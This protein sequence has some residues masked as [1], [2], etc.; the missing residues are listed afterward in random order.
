MVRAMTANLTI[1]DQLRSW[2]QHRR[3]SQLDLAL[4]ANISPRHLSFVETGRAQPSRTMILHLCEQLQVPLRERNLLLLAAGFAPIFPERA[5]G[6]PALAAARA[7]IGLVVDGHEPYPA[8]AVDRHWHL[9][10]ANQAATRLLQGIDPA[11][12]APPV[13]A[14][15]ISLHPWGLAP[16]IRNLA[17]WRGH[18][19]ARLR[20]QIDL[21]A[22][23]ALVALH[24]ELKSYPAPA[25]TAP[26]DRAG[27]AA[28]VVPLVLASER[29]DLSL[30]STTTVFGT[31]I[32]VTLS[33]LAIEAFYAADQ[34]TAEALRLL[35]ADRPLHA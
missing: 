27:T 30:F 32:D 31:P 14:L 10:S 24:D 29:G 3:L 28:M 34:A 21:C 9:V 13:N 5:L 22:D 7:A 1:G 25:R 17:A 12:L 20:Q 23:P 2:R 16:R 15:R 8:L 35:A 33:E 11:L 6:D 18:L 19:L 4:E 26:D